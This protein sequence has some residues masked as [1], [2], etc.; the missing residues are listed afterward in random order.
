VKSFT[1]VNHVQK[2]V[3]TVSIMGVLRVVSLLYAGRSGSLV[4][5][6]SLVAEWSD[7]Y[8]GVGCAECVVRRI[9]YGS[10]DHWPVKKCG[11]D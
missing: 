8:V 1:L 10:T 2:V 11:Q 9:G 6:L 3:K 7:G 4:G 5:W